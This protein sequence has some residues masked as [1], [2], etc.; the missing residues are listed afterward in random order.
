MILHLTCSEGNQLERL[1]NSLAAAYTFFTQLLFND[2]G[3]FTSSRVVQWEN[4]SLFSSLHRFDTFLCLAFYKKNLWSSPKKKRNKKRKIIRQFSLLKKIFSFRNPRERSE[5]C[6]FISR[7]WLEP[8][9]SFLNC[10]Y[11]SS[12]QDVFLKKSKLKGSFCE[13]E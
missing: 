10:W 8:S 12:K 6:G 13:T 1:Q 5:A 11:L 4:E 7:V 3:K 9:F 2:G